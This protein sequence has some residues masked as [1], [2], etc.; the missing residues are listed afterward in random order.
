M[1]GGENFHVGSVTGSVVR[2]EKIEKKRR[3]TLKLDNDRVCLREN[4]SREV[5]GL[6]RRQ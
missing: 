2:I 5:T 3:R 6:K 4:E 1:Y